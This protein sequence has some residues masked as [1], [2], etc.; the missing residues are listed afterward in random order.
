MAFLLNTITG[1][2]YFPNLERLDIEYN[3][4]TNIDVS[5]NTNLER[6]NLNGNNLTDAV[7][8]NLVLPSSLTDL[9]L[10]DIGITNFNPTTALPS[11]LTFLNLSYNQMTLAGYTASEPWA[12]AMSVIPGRGDI[13]INGN[14]NSASG[15]NLETILISKGWTVAV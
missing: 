9:G 15:T 5:Q 7:V 8:N 11:G 12:N 2:G 14:V 13:F 3:D 4:L 6:L 1:L 10:A